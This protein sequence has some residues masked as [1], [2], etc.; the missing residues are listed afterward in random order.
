M[1]GSN[2]Y[3]LNE[4]DL[5]PS[6]ALQ[7]VLIIPHEIE[8]RHVI[9]INCFLNEFYCKYIWLE[10]LINWCYYEIN[11]TSLYIYIY[12]D[13]EFLFTT[14]T[15]NAKSIVS[16]FKVFLCAYLDLM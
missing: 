10:L 11:D 15:I 1:V 12:E 16:I 5:Y 14:L 13:F 3:I 6:R 2:E 7:N 4:L 9:L 8:R